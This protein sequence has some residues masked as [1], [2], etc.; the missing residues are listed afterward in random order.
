M[1]AVL[2]NFRNSLPFEQPRIL[3]LRHFGSAAMRPLLEREA[4]VWAET[5]SWDYSSSAEMILRYMD[6]KILPGLVAM[7]NDRPAG[8]AFYVYEGS[9]GVVGDLFAATSGGEAQDEHVR[10]QLAELVIETLQN[11]PGVDRV[12]AQLLVHRS[13]QTAKPFLQAGFRR[14]TRLFMELKLG[15]AGKRR[16]L[17][18]PQVE[19]RP[20]TE[21]DF[22][23]AGQLITQAYAGHIDSEINDQYRSLGGAM[24]FL[25]N[26]V[27]FPGC[28]VFDAGSSLVAVS[29][30]TGQMIGLLLCSRVR[31]DVGHV[32]QVCLAPDHRGRGL[33]EALMNACA[34]ELAR[35]GFQSLSL[36]VTENN[37]QAVELYRKLGFETRKMFDAFVWQQ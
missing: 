18:F 19:L 21:N 22:Q 34:R 3:D 16:T 11:T 5:M 23:P 29:R 7:E 17:V 33:G 32:T 20:W 28:G 31:E 25:N 15:P 37:R 8:Y 36:T 35:R 14:F 9:K 1:S 2:A 30:E 4:R 26:I 24:R 27:R 12:E 13:G 10:V 6:A